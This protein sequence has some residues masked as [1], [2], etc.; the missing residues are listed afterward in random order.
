MLSFQDTGVEG[1]TDG[2]GDRRKIKYRGTVW[3]RRGR[4]NTGLSV[5]DVPEYG[6]GCR[7]RGGG[8]TPIRFGT[9]NIW[10]RRNSGLESALR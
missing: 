3:E 10:N 8:R 7:G 1:G 5:G 6:T 9:Y 4:I 2:V